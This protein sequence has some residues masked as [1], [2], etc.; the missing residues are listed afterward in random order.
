MSVYF[1]DPKKKDGYLSNFYP[2]P[3]K[4]KEDD[5]WVTYPTSEHYFQVKKFEPTIDMTDVQK[6]NQRWFQKKILEQNTAGKVKF[7]SAQSLKGG[8][9]AW[10]KALK[11]IIKESIERKVIMRKDWE[12]PKSVNGRIFTMIIGVVS[13]FSQN[14]KLLKQLLE[15]GDKKLYEDSPRDSFWGIGKDKKGQNWL[16][17]I[18]VCTR[19]TFR[20][21]N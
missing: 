18:L 8:R 20:K 2:A 9:W 6:D 19:D 14:K 5:R 3:F 11:E 13:K 15:T 7:L 21:M 17:R 4:M 12:D 16:G 10:H 1:Y